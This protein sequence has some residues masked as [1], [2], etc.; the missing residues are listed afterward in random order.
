MFVHVGLGCLVRVM[1]GVKSVPPGNMRMMGRL[2][3]LAAFVMLRC[4][5][6]VSGPLAGTQP[7]SF[8]SSRDL[9]RR[10]RY[11]SDLRA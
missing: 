10:S 9:K 3:V 5:G 7:V 2:F 1:P 4:F 6:M 8:F 11:A